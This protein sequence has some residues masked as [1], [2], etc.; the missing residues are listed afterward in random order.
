[1]LLASF[2]GIFLLFF[3]ILVGI[4]AKFL[5]PKIFSKKTSFFSQK[6]EDFRQKSQK[7]QEKDV[8]EG[9]FE[10]LDREENPTPKR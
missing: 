1:M 10:V 9:D 5:F 3:L 7:K 8:I 2:A 6:F 4:L